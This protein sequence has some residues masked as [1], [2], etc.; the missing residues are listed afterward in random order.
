VLYREGELDGA[1]RQYRAALQ[2][3]PSP[4]VYNDLAV[5]YNDLGMP[6]RA[7]EL[8]QVAVQMNPDFADAHNNL[9]VAYIAKGLYRMAIY[10]LNKAV[11]LDPSFS[12]AYSNLG[13]SYEWLGMRDDAIINYKKALQLD[14]NNMTARNRLSTLSPGLN[15]Q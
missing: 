13:L 6:D 9:G 15:A 7:I 12:G 2:L 10:H 1:V 4:K 11:S 14:A 3:Q 5:A 8:L